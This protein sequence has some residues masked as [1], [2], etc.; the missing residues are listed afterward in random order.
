MPAPLP[1]PER[2]LV[3][4]F[5]AQ[6]VAHGLPKLRVSRRLS[7]V[8]ERHS[9]DLLRHDRLDHTSTDGTPF[10][11]RIGRIGRFRIKGEVL[12]F[13]PRGKTRARSVVRMFMRSP[14]HRAQILDPRFRVIG[15]GRVRGNLVTTRGAM[16]TADLGGR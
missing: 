4:E 3:Q 12:A 16:V 10:S 13:A 14:M 9:R 11:R 7:R 15:V 6:R 5:N 2:A 8:A 1:P